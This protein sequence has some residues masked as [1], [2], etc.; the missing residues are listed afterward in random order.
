MLKYLKKQT[1][2]ATNSFYLTFA[3]GNTIGKV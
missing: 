2:M 1:K 3:F